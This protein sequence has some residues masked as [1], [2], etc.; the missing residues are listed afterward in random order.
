VCL[1]SHSDTTLLAKSV[2]SPPRRGAR[3]RGAAGP[4]RFSESMSHGTND[5]HCAVCRPGTND[6]QCAVC[7]THSALCVGPLRTS[8]AACPRHPRAQRASRDRGSTRAAAHPGKASGGAGRTG[9][10]A[11]RGVGRGGRT[12]PPITISSRMWCTCP[13]AGVHSTQ[14]S[15][16]ARAGVDAAFAPAL[17][18]AILARSGPGATATMLSAVGRDA[19]Q[20]L[21]GAPPCRCGR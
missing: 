3:G 12:I 16:C 7:R 1:G 9:R 5:T 17:L 13:P 20:A 6:T 14:R 18:S 2:V 10:G 19:V 15:R 4:R 8:R 21:R 11:P